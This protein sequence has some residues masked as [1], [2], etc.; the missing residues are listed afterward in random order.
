M[1]CDLCGEKGTTLETVH[2]SLRVSGV[3]DICLGCRDQINR[4]IEG[5]TKQATLHTREY[6]EK[7]IAHPTESRIRRELRE[8]LVCGAQVAG[9]VAAIVVLLS[10]AAYLVHWLAP[11]SWTDKEP[12]A[13]EVP[14]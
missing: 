13:V 7:M 5:Q 4:F 3:K 2:S 1:A 11:E 14:K 12:V 10:V 8:G 9:Y 6:I